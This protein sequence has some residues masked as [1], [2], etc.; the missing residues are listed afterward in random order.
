MWICLNCGNEI[1]QDKEPSC[2]AGC[3]THDFMRPDQLLDKLKKI[4]PII[5]VLREAH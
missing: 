5:D 2:C 3:D 1:E 4:Q